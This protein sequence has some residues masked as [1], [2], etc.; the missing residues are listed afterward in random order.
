MSLQVVVEPVAALPLLAQNQVRLKQYWNELIA[1]VPPI[2]LPRHRERWPE[3]E[4]SIGDITFHP[5]GRNKLCW[6][7]SGP[8]KQQLLPLCREIKSRLDGL[9][10]KLGKGAGTND[11]SIA[12]NV[13]MVGPTQDRA[14]PIIIVC[15]ANEIVRKR[16]VKTIRDL[17]FLDGLVGVK[18]GNRAYSPVPITNEDM[19]EIQRPGHS[20]IGLKVNIAYTRHGDV[21]P[22]GAAIYFWTLGS[23]PAR[24]QATMGGVVTINGRFYGM[25]ALHASSGRPA[26]GSGILSSNS[27]ELIVEDGDNESSRNGRQKSLSIPF[28][29]CLNADNKQDVSN[30][31]QLSVS[32]SLNNTSLGPSAMDSLSRN[33]LP[34]T[35]L[36]ELGSIY[37]KN[38]D[39]DYVLFEI[40]NITHRALNRLPEPLHDLSLKWT[41]RLTDPPAANVLV[42]TGTTGVVMGRLSGMP[43]FLCMPGRKV[44]QEMWVVKLT[45]KASR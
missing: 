9:Y 12:L 4:R 7:V 35:E 3:P 27:V 29:E 41:K 31:N 26:S 20:N 18:L 10:D 14:S 23:P 36:T 11:W 21:N 44:F 43:F 39:L 40:N 37:Y 19:V 25:T 17:E 34:E 13:F 28:H 30:S 32:P 8:A 6:E 15:C 33:T 16:A 42:M 2:I 22:C 5:L 24:Q 1:L 45:R 38:E